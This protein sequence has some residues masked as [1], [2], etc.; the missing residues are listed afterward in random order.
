MLVHN[1]S[2]ALDCC[3]G[4]SIFWGGVC[5][6]ECGCSGFLSN[7]FCLT[8]IVGVL[9]LCGMLFWESRLCVH[10]DCAVIDNSLCVPRRWPFLNKG[11]FSI[12]FPALAIS[13]KG[14]LFAFFFC[15]ICVDVSCSLF[16]VGCDLCA[17]SWESV[18]F[19][20]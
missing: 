11:V 2:Y 5:V 19:I 17:W 7:I 6:C 20:V 9:V 15:P 1:R 13:H 16:I 10:F 14:C 18:F 4:A 3:D 8:F 12:L